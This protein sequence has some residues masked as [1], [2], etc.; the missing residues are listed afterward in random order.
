[1]IPPGE[2]REQ[3]RE[4][5]EM[6]GMRVRKRCWSK[7]Q[8]RFF[9]QELQLYIQLILGRKKLLNLPLHFFFDTNISFQFTHKASYVC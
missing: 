5:R 1:M 6:K 3:S 8:E 2:R 7:G 9:L 4:E